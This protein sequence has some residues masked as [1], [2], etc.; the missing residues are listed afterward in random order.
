MAGV[1]NRRVFE[2]FGLW[3]GLSYLRQILLEKSGRS[4]HWYAHLLSTRCFLKEPLQLK[5]SEHL[6]YSA[7]MDHDPF[8][9]GFQISELEL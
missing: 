2:E 8:P 4:M 9:S 3:D 1:I 7:A 5:T 6:N